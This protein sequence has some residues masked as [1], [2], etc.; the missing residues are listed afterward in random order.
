MVEDDI[1]GLT[2]LVTG[3]SRRLHRHRAGH[4][5]PAPTRQTH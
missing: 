3:L 2:S 4:A 1:G 5:A